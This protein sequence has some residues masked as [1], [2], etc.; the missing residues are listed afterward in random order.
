MMDQAS[1]FDLEGTNQSGVRERNE[2]LVLS[3][4]RREGPLPKAEIARRTGLSAQTASVIMRA[5][6]SDGLISKGE[7]V[8]GRV[9]QPS[10]PMSLAPD[11]VYFFGLSVGRRSVEL[12]LTNFLGK[13]I[14]H[15]RK[16]YAYPL[17]SDIL[18]FVQ[19]AS[20]EI[21]NDLKHEQVDRIS[22]MGVA[23]PFFLWDWAITIGADPDKM[24]HWKHCDL[25]FELS[26]LFQFPIYFG[27]DAS[28][29]CGAEL[30]FGTVETPADFLYIYF[31]HF[32]GGG[33]VMNGALYTG[34]SGNAGAIG[35]FPIKGNQMVEVASL[36]GLER[37]LIEA[38]GSAAEIIEK[39]ENWE[40]DAKIL[41]DWLAEAVPAVTRMIVGAISIIDFPAVLIDGNLP[42]ELRKILVDRIA[43]EMKNENL[44][45]LVKPQIIEGSLGPKA[46][47]M[48]AVSLPLAKRYMFEA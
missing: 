40:L 17:P 23:I 41:D 30:V 26:K 5:L 48:G 25:Q 43:T 7:K 22:G 13:D 24:N 3:I 32:I 28:C 46:R 16:S 34:S 12:I 9:G 4:L 18:D 38:T 6:E 45:G 8:R 19:I 39:T 20:A 14:A 36:N 11:G 21:I 31:G 1:K 47:P 27:N 10:V 33:V 44:A 37:R 15:R 29:A 42:I 2:R 35:P